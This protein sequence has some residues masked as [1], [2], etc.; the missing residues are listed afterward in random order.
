MDPRQPTTNSVMPN[1]Q[2]TFRGD[3]CWYLTKDLRH[4]SQAH[5][6]LGYFHDLFF[7]VDRQHPVV[8]VIS[9]DGTILERP[10]SHVSFAQNKPEVKNEA[11]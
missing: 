1:P 10:S 2:D 3:A 11:S 8:I 4:S 9:L 7:S 6:S 5:W